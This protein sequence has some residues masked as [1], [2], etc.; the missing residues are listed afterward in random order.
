MATK[1][2]LLG[3]L[4]PVRAWNKKDY[5]DLIFLDRF[6]RPVKAGDFIVY[7]PTNTAQ[8]ADDIATRILMLGL[9][10]GIEQKDMEVRTEEGGTEFRKQLHFVGFYYK[11]G[12][13]AE[14]VQLRKLWVSSDYKVCKVNIHDFRDTAIYSMALVLQQHMMMR[15]NHA[16]QRVRA[17][18]VIGEIAN[19]RED[20]T[21]AG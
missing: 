12:D 6:H 13:K 16:R 17:V 5:K 9:V 19:G 14:D 4:L 21:G 11:P 20:T 18:D 10:T 3:K 7:S 8:I 15:I 1:K 2:D